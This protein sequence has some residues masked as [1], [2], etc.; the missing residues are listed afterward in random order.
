MAVRPPNPETHVKAADSIVPVA[1]ASEPR[2]PFATG[3]L[4]QV[5]S[6]AVTVNKSP[7]IGTGF[8]CSEV[9]TD[10]RDRARKMMSRTPTEGALRL[11]SSFSCLRRSVVVPGSC[12]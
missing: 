8:V 2:P 7:S 4:P 11:P 9:G 1:S 5:G 3:T 10:D 12:S 6:S